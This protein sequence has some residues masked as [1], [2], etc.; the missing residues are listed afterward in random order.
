MSTPTRFEL[1]CARQRAKHGDRFVAPTDQRWIDAFNRGVEYRVKVRTEWG[2]EVSERWGFVSL[3]TGWVP[4]F[5]LMRST[6][7]HGS[8]DLLSDRDQIV[9]ARY[10]SN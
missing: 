9:A 2:S 1:Y 10:K 6:R 4:S 8:S 5:M 7:A 3:T